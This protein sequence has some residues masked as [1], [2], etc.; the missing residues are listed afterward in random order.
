MQDK[1]NVLPCERRQPHECPCR[2]L[3]QLAEL[4]GELFEARQE[5]QVLRAQ[6]RLGE[7]QVRA[8]QPHLRRLVQSHVGLW[9][10]NL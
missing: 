10:A 4:E 6:A 2:E 8:R 9:R 3:P 5:A 1:M 7:E